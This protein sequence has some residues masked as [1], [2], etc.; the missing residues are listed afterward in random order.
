MDKENLAVNTL[1]FLEQLKQG[2]LQ[3]NLLD[4]LNAM[5]I[6]KVEIRREF[7]QNFDRELDAI[8]NKAKQL[9]MEVYY[10]VPEL[11]YKN[12]EPSFSDLEKYLAEAKVMN[13]T[14]IKLG[15]GEYRE[16]R[17]EDISKLNKLCEDYNILLTIENDQTQENGQIHK[18]KQFL[19]DVSALGSKILAT[20]DIGNWLWQKEDPMTNAKLLKQYVAYIHL[21]DV[22]GGENPQATLLDEGDI[23]WRQILK[24]LPQVPLA[25]EYPCGSNASEQ[26]AI[27]LAKLAK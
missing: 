16:A 5:D 22:K 8:G 3:E 9:N 11:L 27:E 17:N 2:V 12:G 1:V 20:F 21:K 10:S 15:I 19:E 14:R 25:L 7:I 23:E 26:L 6:T 13:A 24:E 4:L 18:I